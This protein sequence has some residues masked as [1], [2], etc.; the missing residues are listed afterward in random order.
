METFKA[1]PEAAAM[2]RVLPNLQ[3]A[4]TERE[5]ARIAE[6]YDEILLPNLANDL[7]LMEDP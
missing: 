3:K 5:D 1:L 2:E 4:L 6:S 7:T